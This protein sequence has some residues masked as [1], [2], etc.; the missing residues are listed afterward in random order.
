MIEL[1]RKL[2]RTGVVFFPQGTI[3]NYGFNFLNDHKTILILYLFWVKV[4][5]CI[6]SKNLSI[7]S[8]FMFFYK[9]L[10]FLLFFNC[11]SSVIVP[12]FISNIFIGSFPPS[13][14]MSCQKCQFYY[15][16]KKTNIWFCQYSAMYID[17][18]YLINNCYYF[19]YFHP[20]IF[21]FIIV[22]VACLI[23]LMSA[24]YFRI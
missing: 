10:L 20:S 23:Y 3:F 24:S 12:I 22:K 17:F 21:G 1:T 8:I 14:L 7:S 4:L 2:S 19:Y 6:F 18:F 5:S 16:F 9:P 13:F 11:G 15:S